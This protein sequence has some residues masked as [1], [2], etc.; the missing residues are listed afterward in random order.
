MLAGGFGTAVWESL[1]PRRAPLAP[2]IL[3]VGLPDRYVTHGAPALLHE[4]VGFTR[5][6]HRRARRSR[7]ARPR[8]SPC[9]HLNALLVE[10]SVYDRLRNPGR[11]TPF[12][13]GDAW[14]S[15][16]GTCHG[17]LAPP[18]R[19]IGVPALASGESARSRARSSRVDFAF[20]NPDD[21]RQR[22]HDQRRRDGHVQLPGG[23]QL[24]QRRL[25]DRSPRRR[26][27][28]RPARTS[29]PVPPLP[30]SRQA[31]GWAGVCRFNTPGTY[32]S[33]ARRTAS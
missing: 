15:G 24:P 1:R 28:R 11:N 19:P 13:E 26:A 25:P 6:A 7:R 3:R 17:W 21:R 29:A 22:G 4:E 32:G 2:R 14:D 30:R 5:R 33:S 27:R 12:P 16:R 20:E 31:P 10:R 8:A 23:R 18:S 9:R